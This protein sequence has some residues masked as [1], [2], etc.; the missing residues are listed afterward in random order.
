M[1]L[2]ERPYETRME[3][4]ATTICVFVVIKLKIK[5]LL[6]DKSFILNAEELI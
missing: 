2:L 1:I 3:I 4:Q 6:A 5:H